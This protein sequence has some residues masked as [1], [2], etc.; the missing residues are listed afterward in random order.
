MYNINEDEEIILFKIDHSIPGFKIPIIEY[1]LFTQDGSIQFN[2]SFCDKS[3]IQ[4]NLPASIN[5]SEL[6]KYDNSSNYYND[7]CYP[8]TSENNTDIPLS[9]R[10]KEYNVNNMS[11]CQSDCIFRGYNTSTK[12]VYCECNIASNKPLDLK[13]IDIT[14]LLK[15][16]IDIKNLM[17]YGVMKCYKVLF[18][19]EG[20]ISN[21]GSYIML[22]IIFI[23]LME[24]SIFFI[25]GK[26]Q[27]FEEIKNII[28]KIADGKN[29]KRKGKNPINVK[30]EKLDSNKIIKFV[31]NKISSKKT[32]TELSSQK[33]GIN[34]NNII[35]QKNE[36]INNEEIIDSSEIEEDSSKEKNELKNDSE[37]NS[38]SFINALRFD[39]RTYC[40]YYASLIR[41]KQLLVF[42]FYTKN[43]F[44][45]RMIKICLFYS[46]F[47][48]YYTVN[49]LFF[50]DSTMNK[51]YENKGKE[52]ISLRIPQILYSTIISTGIKVLL[53]TF[54]LTEKNILEIKNQKNIKLVNDT[55][56]IN[57]KII[58]RKIM[59]FFGVNFI[60]LLFFWYYLSSFCAV[61]KNTQTYLIKDTFISFCLSLVYPFFINL[62]PGIFRIMALKKVNK[63]LYT[64]SKL[65]ALI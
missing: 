8:Y 15:K 58:N 23:T 19:K 10:K 2:L 65:I 48:L 41:N 47:A 7:I 32:I 62:I 9:T 60:F 3:S 44:N 57:F 17:N 18:S 59:I 16:F 4:Y 64:I 28:S 37:L 38:L 35:F 61:Y 39:K 13:N 46:S 53:T 11:L 50:N 45:S 24:Y 30:K 54:S 22:F 49:T 43:D 52:N 36:K 40:Q 51:I 31:E 34:S 56:L 20:L 33:D 25:E 27:Y 55:A 14:L 26:K 29:I 42:V 5:S 1:Y 21:I 6:F 12:N 63:L